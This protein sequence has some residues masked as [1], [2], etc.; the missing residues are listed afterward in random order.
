[1]TNAA[2]WIDTDMGFD[3]FLAISMVADAGLP[4]QG[5]SLVFG[6]SP[7]SRV[8]ENSARAV[9]F[10]GWRWPVHLGAARS[11]LGETLTAGHVLGLTGMASRHRQLPAAR[12]L[13][14]QSTAFAALANWLENA[15]KPAMVLA[16][17]PLTNLAI[18][19][20]ARPELMPKID[21]LVWMGGSSGPGNQTPCA[22]FNA[23]A[24]P[25]AVAIMLASGVAM[26]MIDLELCRQVQVAPADMAD[27]EA[28]GCERA[29]VLQDLMGGYIDIGLSR[30][31]TAMALYDPVAAAALT[32]PDAFEFVPAKLDVELAGHKTRGQTLVDRRAGPSTVA[33]IGIAVDAD[34]VKSMAF[35]ALLR[36]AK[37]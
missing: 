9:A 36:L 34:H 37:P 22:E 17:G 27:L 26:R 3:D 25:E 12:A 5:M 29:A 31:R 10:A 18:L 20:L 30:G 21:R 14:A 11:I 4:I 35:N 28:L 33:E 19:A 15:A 16:L 23:V 7:L 2:V 32:H 1:M 24:D 6:N 13:P 8:A